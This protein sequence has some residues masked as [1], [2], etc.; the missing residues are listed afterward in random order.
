MNRLFLVLRCQNVLLLTITFVV[1][2]FQNQWL[3]AADDLPRFARADT[4]GGYVHWIELLDENSTKVNPNDPN[5]RPYSPKKTCGRCHD[6]EQISHGWHFDAVEQVDSEK[7]R[8]GQPWIWS[9][10]RTGTYLP[11][12]Y[13]DWQ[14]T[15]NPDKL[16]ITRWAIAKQFGGFLPGGGPGSMESLKKTSSAET[17]ATKSE[18]KSKDRTAITGE[19]PIDCMLCHRSGGSYSAE[20]W[21]EQ[22]EAENFAYAPT[23]AAGLA[24]IEG[25]LSRVRDSLEEAEPEFLPKL[26]YDVDQFRPDGKVFFNITRKPENKSCYHCHTHLPAEN[27]AFERWTHDDDV[28]LR[29]GMKCVD[30]HRHGL[31]HELVRGYDGQSYSR[32]E[33][34]STLSCQGCHL[35]VSS[36]VEATTHEIDVATI[37]M[38]EGGR[39]G[40]PKP[41]HAGLPPLHFDKLSCTACHS[42]PAIASELG[43]QL[44]SQSHHLGGHERRS[45]KELPAVFGPAMLPEHW[46]SDLQALSEKPKSDEHDK[47]SN[48]ASSHRSILGKY[49]PHRLMW[50]S[51]WGLF[52]DGSVVP[53]DPE[54]SYLLTRKGL[55]VKKDL[56]EE[57]GEVKPSLTDRKKILGDER[58]KVKEEE[59]T[60][61]ERSKVTAWVDEQSQVQ[62]D[63]RIVDALE[64]IAQAYP[65]SGTPVFVTGG[66]VFRQLVGE[67]KKI[68]VIPSDQ[69]KEAMQPTAWPIAHNVRSAR[70]SLGVSGCLECHQSGSAFFTSTVQANGVLPGKPTVES[71]VH[72]LQQADMVRLESWN[73]MFSSRSLFKYFAFGCLGLSTFITLSCLAWSI[74]ERITRRGGKISG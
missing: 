20:T 61:E 56:A 64:A 40:A 14:G 54:E 63:T 31:D 41:I 4:D 3:G 46:N 37:W 29:A 45:G 35:G 39:L 6:F 22:I 13:R 38:R 11:L 34:I 49:T 12:S 25:A 8:S 58:A 47:S 24:T 50:P 15:Y 71:P 18:A 69:A 1:G 7:G 43:R 36:G 21:T 73:E 10:P 55:K 19:L 27:I 23:V 16:G 70:H 9:D 57:I 2:S 59:W 53:L 33:L 26:K 51:F 28:H 48:D 17:D 32:P 44:T 67:T 60:E 72:E 65:D 42:G 74:G 68:E 30:C 52:K 62:I 66:Q 5:A